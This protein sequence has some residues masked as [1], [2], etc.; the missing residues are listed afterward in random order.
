MAI[1]KC[2]H[3]GNDISDKAVKCV[4]C[5]ADLVE[6]ETK[7]C[8][9]CASELEDGEEYCP[10]CGCP[11]ENKEENKEISRIPIP[12]K[13]MIMIGGVVILAIIFLVLMMNMSKKNQYEKVLSEAAVIMSEGVDK[14][15]KN[16]DLIK[17]VWY[18]AIYEES[19][20]I[21]DKY[22][23]PYGYFVSDFNE[24]LYNLFDDSVY[25]NDN[26]F[27]E[28]NQEQMRDVM[29]KLE[30]PPE[31]YRDAY[32][33]IKECYNDYTM[34]TNIVLDPTGS[35]TTFSESYNS[36]RDKAKSSIET[37]KMYEAEE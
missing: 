8:T 12:Q 31:E 25:Q 32:Q 19:D 6:K 37:V 10:K 14:A 13:K 35:Y 17:E 15:E 4:H 3:C 9:E 22:T 33:N 27:L 21:T 20:I 29:K 24:A 5:Q 11:V 23:K 34:L 36:A 18:N 2:P 1:I 16:G 28:T 7:Y 26:S 30:N